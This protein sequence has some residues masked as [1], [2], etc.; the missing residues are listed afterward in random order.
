[1][2]RSSESSG[3][4][5]TSQMICNNMQLFLSTRRLGQYISAEDR[6]RD[7]SDVRLLA[8][9]ASTRLLAK[10]AGEVELLNK[11][12]EL[13][14]ESRSKARL[15][16]S[17]ILAEVWPIVILWQNAAAPE[18]TKL[19]ARFEE[20]RGIESSETAPSWIESDAQAV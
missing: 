8:E 17:V 3:Q 9:I 11:I 1:M 14:L 4:L 20:L 7:P 13:T 6:A 15:V 19:L 5:R 16:R 18:R 10:N 12:S 2:Q